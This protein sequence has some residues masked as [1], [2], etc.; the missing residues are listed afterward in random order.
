MACDHFCFV[1]FQ[2]NFAMT[3]I[4]TNPWTDLR[5]E[6]RQAWPEDVQRV[7]IVIGCSGGADS[8]ALVRLIDESA[9][10]FAAARRSDNHDWKPPRIVIAHFNHG[11]RGGESDGDEQFVREL[12]AAS[13]RTYEVGRASEPGDR[14]A[15]D[16]ATLR[17]HRRNFMID[18]A[19]KHGC[20][21]LATAHT[22]DDQVE[23]VLHHM[24]RGTGPAGLSGMKALSVVAED[25]VW[26]RPL[27]TA[28][29]NRIRNALRHIGQSWREDASNQNSVYTRNWIRNQILPAIRQRMPG[30]D[31][32]ILRVTSNQSQANTLLTGLADQWIDAFTICL[33]AHEARSET[34]VAMKIRID[35]PDREPISNQWPHALLLASDPAIITTACQRLFEQAGWPRGEMKQEHWLRLTELVSGATPTT[36]T[37]VSGT[38]N[39]S[40]IFSHGH[41]PGSI[42]IRS[43]NQWVELTR[44]T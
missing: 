6:F 43:T 25:F 28:R 24:I 36:P 14:L 9:S 27:L 16:E 15:D 1:S 17:R 30:V 8:V 37:A 32:A 33:S 3:S 31:D 19:Q 26:R 23:T 10:E 35:R 12:A 34:G 18:V 21:Y 13:G 4:E 42:E 2:S 29:R 7:G 44:S 20:R 22:A 39:S 11:L 38:E 41:L 5:I 40:G